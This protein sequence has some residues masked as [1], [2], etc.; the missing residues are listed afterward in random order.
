MATVIYLRYGVE[1]RGRRRRRGRRHVGAR[2]G[3]SQHLE[4]DVH[5]VGDAEG[6]GGNA[7]EFGV[8]VGVVQTGL[9]IENVEIF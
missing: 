8:A 6:R 5:E 2:E 9:P 4:D 7:V 1:P 3:K